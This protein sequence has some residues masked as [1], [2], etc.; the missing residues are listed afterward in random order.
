MGK[1]TLCLCAFQHDGEPRPPIFS[2][3]PGGPRRPFEHLIRPTLALAS[4]R[5][6]RRASQAGSTGLLR[7]PCGRKKHV[8]TALDKPTPSDSSSLPFVNPLGLDVLPTKV[9]VDSPGTLPPQTGQLCPD[10]AACQPRVADTET[11]VRSEPPSC[12]HPG[13][14]SARPP[15][16][17]PASQPPGVIGRG[18]AHRLP[19]K[20][21]L[22]L[23]TLG[24]PS[25]SACMR[26]PLQSHTCTSETPMVGA[27]C[28]SNGL[29]TPMT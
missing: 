2:S 9:P 4:T 13:T 19:P 1:T 22:Y 14:A 12:E 18:H 15:A 28:L 11:V 26:S 10:D 23:S 20:L 27:I 3:Q 8:G 24:P 6:P 21:P 17:L 5:R 7:A 29:R 25:P 16:C